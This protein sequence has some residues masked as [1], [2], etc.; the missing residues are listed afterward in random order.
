[1]FRHV[2]AILRV[3][4]HQIWNLLITDYISNIRRTQQ[5]LNLVYELPND[6]CRNMWEWWKTI[7][8]CLSY[9]PLFGFINE[10]LKQHTSNGLTDI[11]LFIYCSFNAARSPDVLTWNSRMICEIKCKE[12][13]SNWLRGTIPLV[14]SAWEKK[15][16]V[17]NLASRCPSRNPNLIFPE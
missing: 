4:I 7:R 15:K 10:H 12:C 1:M 16:K 9:V 14:W 2:R 17:M 5:L 3:F 8:I 13:C 11:R 6:K